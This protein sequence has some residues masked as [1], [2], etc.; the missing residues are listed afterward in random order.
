MDTLIIQWLMVVQAERAT[1]NE[2]DL[3]N[4]MPRGGEAE[5]AHEIF[6]HILKDLGHET[7]FKFLDKN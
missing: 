2:D 7:G 1:R 4:L 3:H 5:D 6:L